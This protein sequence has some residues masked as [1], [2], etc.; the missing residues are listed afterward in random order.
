MVALTALEIRRKPSWTPF[1][2]VAVVLAVVVVL[3]GVLYAV[4]GLNCVETFRIALINEKIFLNGMMDAG[5]K[6]CLPQTIPFD[7]LEFLKGMGWIALL[8]V[9][10]AWEKHQKFRSIIA[11]CVMQP[12]LVALVG[13]LQIETARIWLFMI[14]LIMIPAGLALSQWPAQRRLSCFFLLGL[15]SAAVFRNLSL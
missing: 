2:Q 12:V 15:I 9:F 5:H 11:L 14:P 3:Y 6:R 7:L 10:P 1:R 13:I 4:T 8:L